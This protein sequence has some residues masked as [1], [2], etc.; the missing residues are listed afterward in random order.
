MRDN[1]FRNLL[2]LK[3]AAMSMELEIRL[4]AH[5]VGTNTRSG[6][7]VILTLI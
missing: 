5:Q 4:H 6:T 3:V 1:T 7:K 2:F